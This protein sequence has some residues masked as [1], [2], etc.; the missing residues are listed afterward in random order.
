MVLDLRF[1]GLPARLTAAER[2]STFGRGKQGWMSVVV[3][4]GAVGRLVGPR[5]RLPREAARLV[6][7]SCVRPNVPVGFM[8]RVDPQVS[9]PVDL[10]D[11]PLPSYRHRLAVPGRAGMQIR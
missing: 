2:G 7:R 8:G 4:P 11:C 5:G 1:G 3:E 6:E 10:Q 9:V